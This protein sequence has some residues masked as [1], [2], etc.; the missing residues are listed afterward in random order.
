MSD[1]PAKWQEG[2]LPR[3]RRLYPV[4]LLTLLVGT[5]LGYLI[6]VL[7]FESRG[8]LF[9]PDSRSG[10]YSRTGFP[11]L[12]IIILVSLVPV[13]I[14]VHFV[15]ALGD[16]MR[17][18][19][20]RVPP[21]AQAIVA[22]LYVVMLWMSRSDE[23]QEFL[24]FL[25]LVPLSLYVLSRPPFWISYPIAMLYGLSML[26]TQGTGVMFL[27]LLLLVGCWYYPTDLSIRRFL[28]PSKGVL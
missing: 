3:G 22:V 20:Q 6:A 5:L 24:V 28:R 4:I 27:A 7:A 2:F 13:L 11:D 14:G 1:R 16:F 19:F 15:K 12:S 17:R 18:L 8:L 21:L 26:G 25:L 10:S 9:I 23:T